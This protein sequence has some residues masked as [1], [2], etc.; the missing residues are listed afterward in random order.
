[1]HAFD[2]LILPYK[3]NKN[4]RFPI[5]RV[6]PENLQDILPLCGYSAILYSM[7]GRPPVS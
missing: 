1:M 3:R 2:T 4:K 5:G 6:L 7:Q